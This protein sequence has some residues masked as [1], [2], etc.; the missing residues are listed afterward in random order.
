M[1]RNV[2][3]NF[4]HYFTASKKR[5]SMCKAQNNKMKYVFYINDIVVRVNQP[6]LVDG[7]I[8]FQEIQLKSFQIGKISYSKC[9][10]ASLLKVEN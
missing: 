5:G 8:C 3:K 1:S 2:Q 6:L 9:Q 10:R 7:Y 4:D